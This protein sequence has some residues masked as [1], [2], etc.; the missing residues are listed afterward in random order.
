AIFI[1]VENGWAIG[2]D[3]GLLQS[4]YDLG[5]RYM[6][7]SHTKNNDICD[8]STDPNGY[9][10]G[11][12][13][14][15]GRQ[16]VEEMNRIGLLIDV[17]HISDAAVYDCLKYSKAPIAATHSSARALFD[18]PRNLTDDLIK[19]IAANGGVIQMNFLTGYLR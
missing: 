3:I 10:H 7:L 12:L 4:Y 16:V 13:T 17:S 11:G 14:E 2:K 18:H 6:T 1:G 9:E 15:F 19:A 5:A 8:S